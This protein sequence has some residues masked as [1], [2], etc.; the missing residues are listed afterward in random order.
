MAKRPNH[1]A[2]RAA[3]TYT[4]EEA[5]QSLGVSIGTVRT[6][7]RSGLPLMTSRRPFLILGDSLRG[8]LQDR[9]AGAKVRLRP[10][11]LYCFACK[12]GCVPMGLMVDC[13]PQTAKTARL[14]GL[15]SRCGGP[16]NRM[17]SRS[18]IGQIS[19][20]FDLAMKDSPTA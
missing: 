17:V 13:I 3:R 15:C 14:M 20:L 10:D 8:F 19:G 18:N 2:I 6:W 16:C 11:Q 4:I 9:T 12:A 1:R 5:A 7:V